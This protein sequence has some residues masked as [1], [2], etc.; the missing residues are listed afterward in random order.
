MASINNVNLCGRLT[1]EIEIQM[2]PSGKKVTR[3]TIAVQRN[4]EE[5]DFPTCQAWEKTAEILG[6]YTKKG[7]KLNIQ[8]SIRT[9]SYDTQNGKVYQT[10]IL[11][12]QIELLEP[13]KD[14]PKQEPKQEPKREEKQQGYSIA[15]DDL[16]FY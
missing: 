3:F 11:V 6:Q 5:A 8:G 9:A 10:Y 16:P 2:T 7:D 14:E 4:K 12:N 15:T 13:R 1:K